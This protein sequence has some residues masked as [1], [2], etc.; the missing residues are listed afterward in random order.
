MPGRPESETYNQPGVAGWS[1]V[2]TDLGPDAGHQDAVDA[3]QLDVDLEAEVGERLRRGLVDVLGLDALGGQAEDGVSHPLHLGCGRNT[4]HAALSAE[5]TA[6]YRCSECI[7]PPASPRLWEEHAALSAEV[8]A[9]YRCSECILT[10]A[11]PRLWEKRAALS[12][13][14]TAWYGCPE[15]ILTPASPRLWEKRAALS[16]EA[17][18]W[19]GCSE[20]ARRE[21]APGS[22]DDGHCTSELTVR[23][24]TDKH[25]EGAPGS[26]DD[27]Q[28]PVS[29]PSE[30]TQINT[31]KARLVVKTMDRYQ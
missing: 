5:V 4:R 16:A 17:T 15:C 29:S 2:V 1:D 7:L 11:S 12:A 19:Y 14:A 8:T 31:Q 28:V 3:A 13:E 6:W 21:G 9:W 25:T 18:A 30:N 20:R 10:P 24:H 22:E 26:E 23:K 27:G